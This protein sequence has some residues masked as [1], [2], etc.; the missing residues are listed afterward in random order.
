M[1]WSLRSEANTPF[2]CSPRQFRVESSMAR[3]SQQ[4]RLLGTKWFVVVDSFW[5][6]FSFRGGLDTGLCSGLGLVSSPR[7]YYQSCSGLLKI[8]NLW[9]HDSSPRH[10]ASGKAL[11]RG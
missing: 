11:G 6:P 9:I 10:V 8:K 4:K 3:C 2:L 1:S 5:A 7:K